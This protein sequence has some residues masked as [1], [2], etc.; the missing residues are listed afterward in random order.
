MSDKQRGYLY[1]EAR[2]LGVILLVFALVFASVWL[3]QRCEEQQRKHDMQMASELKRPPP[4]FSC[5]ED[6]ARCSSGTFCNRYKCEPELEYPF[7]PLL[8]PCKTDDMCNARNG[9]HFICIHGRCRSCLKD[10]ECGSGFQCK[11]GDWICT[12]SS[13]PDASVPTPSASH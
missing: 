8:N 2:I 5:A 9:A 12:P 3:Y 10:E 7:Y 1:Y 13:L 6:D 4:L 11:Q